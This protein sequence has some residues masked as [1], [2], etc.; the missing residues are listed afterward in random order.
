LGEELFE[1][2]FFIRFNLDTQFC[3]K[4]VFKISLFGEFSLDFVTYLM[5]TQKNALDLSGMLKILQIIEEMLQKDIRI[6]IS[7]K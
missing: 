1:W 4:K 3:L 5:Q 7:V 2:L 6:I